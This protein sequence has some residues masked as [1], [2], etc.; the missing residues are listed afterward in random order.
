MEPYY[1]YSDYLKHKYG[2]KVYRIP[3][4]L[5]LTCPNR[6]G[7]IG[8]GGCTFCGDI[9]AG[10]E[11]LEN[12]QTVEEQLES[13]I[14]Y[15]GPRYHAKKFIAYFQNYTNTYVQQNLFE[16]YILSA[17]R[18]DVVEIAISTRPDCVTEEQLEYLSQ[19]KE[20]Y[21]K[22][23]NIELGLQS[24]NYHTLNKINR[25]HTLAE[26]ID[27]VNR[28]KKRKFQITVHMIL[29]LPQDDM[30]DIIEG[31]KILSALKIDGVKLHSL[32]LTKG[33]IMAQEYARGELHLGNVEEYVERAAI[34]L[35]YLSPNIAIQRIIG[36]APEK[37]TLNCNFNM[38][39]WKIKDCII[40]FMEDN[41]LIQGCKCD[42]LNGK[43][44]KL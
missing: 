17:I 5:P 3:V 28:C 25:G 4:N 43:I 31:A 1:V 12:T 24:V 32:Y 18:D 6:D 38:S 8:V 21:K 23:I 42:Y 9:G 11:S 16:Q 13:N 14:N 26:F 7:R 39:W 22:E 33:S 30:D 19:I 29:N 10:F 36:R 41:H 40:D 20:T 15:I 34:F 2:E 35:S 37:D 27:C 44:K